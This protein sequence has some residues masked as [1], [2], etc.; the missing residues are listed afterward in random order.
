MDN[1]NDQEKLTIPSIKPENIGTYACNISN[2]AGYEYKM[3]YLDILT[4]EPTFV[5]T[6]TKN[7]IVSVGQTTFLRCKVKAY[8]SASIRWFFEGDEI[9]NSDEYR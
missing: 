6:P 5:E 7:Q 8:P 9:S 4:T 2:E 1:F 3:V